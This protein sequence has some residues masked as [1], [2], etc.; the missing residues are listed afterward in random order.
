VNLIRL[1]GMKLYR[2]PILGDTVTAYKVADGRVLV[3]RRS[4]VARQGV[5]PDAGASNR[6]FKRLMR[7][8]ADLVRE[9]AE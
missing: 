9:S 2:K 6:F 5:E 7:V 4:R 8:S 1:K 3:S